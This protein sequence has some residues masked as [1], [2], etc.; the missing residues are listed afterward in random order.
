[1]LMTTFNRLLRCF[2]ILW[3]ISMDGRSRLPIPDNTAPT[4][5]RCLQ[6]TIPDDDQYETLL[7]SAVSMLS[8]WM[9]YDRDPDHKAALV[10][11]LFK[12]AMKSWVYCDGTP[13]KPLAGITEDIEVPIH[14]DCDCNVTVDCCDGSTVQ[15]ATVDMLNQ[16]SQPGAGTP[17]PSAGGGTQCY[18]VV[19]QA[20]QKWFLPTLV[21]TGDVITFGLPTQMTTGSTND[22]TDS[23]LYCANGSDYALG[24]CN[25]AGA[26]TVSTDP[27]NTDPHMSVLL[28]VNGVYH[29]ISDSS[30][31]VGAGIS[32]S[33]AY[34]I[35]NTN[36]IAIASGSLSGKLCV[37]NNQAATWS[38]TFDFTLSSYGFLTAYSTG[39]GGQWVPGV[40][41]TP[42][43]IQDGVGTWF[44][45]VSVHRLGIA[46][47]HETSLSMTFNYHQ[48]AF[49]TCPGNTAELLVT[50]DGSTP[51]TFVN[52]DCAV[53]TNADNQVAGGIGDHTGQTIIVMQLV[54][55]ENASSPSGFTGVA[56]IKSLTI[57]GKGTEPV[58]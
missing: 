5:E 27:L 52:N 57:N 53:T 14:V 21:S 1:V 58:W 32:N 50:S 47:F 25:T 37:T 18:P 31:T 20:N 16:P 22:G 51:Q 45:G 3:L 28:V 56:A 29:T 19:M 42:T 46:P 44:R 30:L 43:D 49:Q 36:N 34:L 24:S 15:L 6:I 55:D 40:G 17:Q 11:N 4:G 23:L 33:Q 26:H 12:R 38:H 9:V 35:M 48:G 10:A 41:F 8:Y 7:K 13:V 54:T 39:N 2:I